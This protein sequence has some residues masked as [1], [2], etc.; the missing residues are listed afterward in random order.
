[1]RIRRV[2]SRQA[3]RPLLISLRVRRMLKRM[4]DL[5]KLMS[6]E[7]RMRANFLALCE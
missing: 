5:H 1:V 6:I 3:R 7:H 2:A 4:S